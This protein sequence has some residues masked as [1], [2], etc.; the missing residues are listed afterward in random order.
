MRAVSH[1]VGRLEEGDLKMAERFH[2]L[3][4][5][6]K[7]FLACLGDWWKRRGAPPGPGRDGTQTD[8]W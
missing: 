3:L 4:H 8:Q 6:V 2:F 7:R 1:G 5:G